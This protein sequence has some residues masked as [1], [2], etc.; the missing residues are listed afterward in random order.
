MKFRFLFILLFF[1][2]SSSIA[3]GG[4][5]HY[6]KVSAT[7]E[8][9]KGKVYASY[10]PALMEVPEY[11]DSYTTPTA[12]TFNSVSE[13]VFYL[14]AKPEAGYNLVTWK[15]GNAQIGQLPYVCDNFPYLRYNVTGISSTDKAS[16][17]ST[18]FSAIFSSTWVTLSNPYPTSAC[19]ATI[20]RPTNSNGTSVTLTATIPSG[21]N[22]TWVGWRDIHT[23][24]IISTSKTYTFTVDKKMDLEPLIKS[25]SFNNIPDGF[26][27]IKSAVTNSDGKALELISNEF[28]LQSVVGSVSTFEEDAG[29]TRAQTQLRKDLILTDVS[30]TVPAGSVMYLKY[31]G[32]NTYELFSQGVNLKKVTSG[33]HH[34]G[35]A[36]DADYDGSYL[37]ITDK[38]DGKYGLS[39]SIAFSVSNYTVAFT[40][41]LKDKGDNKL[42]MEKTDDDYNMWSIEPITTPI[43]TITTVTSGDIKYTTLRSDFSYVIPNGSNT[44]AYRV[45]SISDDFA[46][47]EEYEQGD[48]I[49]A[50]VPTILSYPSSESLNIIPVGNPSFK[51]N[52]NN[53]VLYNNYGT[54]KHDDPHTDAA[55][56]TVRDGGEPRGDGI[57]YFSKEKYS[58]TL[59]RLSVN[60][61]DVVGFW[62]P[63]TNSIISG[64]E[65]YATQ[66]CALFPKEVNLKDLPTTADQITYKLVD[67]LTVAYVDGTNKVIYAK[68]D[69][70]A[71]E[72][73]AGENVD[74]MA[75]HYSSGEYA[76]AHYG[77]HSNWVAIKVASMP[78]VVEKDMIEA[79][80]KVV[81]G[82]SP[83][84]TIQ[85]RVTKLNSTNSNYNPNTYSIANFYGTQAFNGTTYFFAKPVANEIGQIIWAMW[86]GE[87]FV[88]PQQGVNDSG[89]PINDARLTGSVAPE[90]NLYP[91]TAAMPEKAWVYKF[92][93]LI[94]KRA[95]S[96][97]LKAE[98]DEYVLYP[99][100]PLETMGQMGEGEVYT[101]IDNLGS[102]SVASVKYYNMMGVESDVPFQGVN[103]VVTRYD[104]GSQSTH[105]ML[106]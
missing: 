20:N 52:I 103:I 87:K 59:Y 57:G 70:G 77:D 35:N 101:A 61:N 29:I 2:F 69:N 102:K 58:G 51:Y 28:C 85:G 60:E 23:G 19:T 56:V 42:S 88:V 63:V 1:L 99:L 86:D 33:T 34:G 72:Q 94:Q 5:I 43:K 37:T 67:P 79:T 39:I 38:G 49:Y 48:T 30:Q 81:D 9:G 54:H 21:S 71:D 91:S 6:G 7:G 32:N 96:S 74:F 82:T 25:S 13:K 12:P 62:T 65:A 73:L 84:R 98:T 27:S 97:S 66:P 31:M 75:Q 92:L 55:N 78:T 8:T 36:G 100:T 44:K 90:W 41:N 14:Y 47:L 26:Y 89:E 10:D 16:P 4:S 68:D 104:D 22:S 17:T 93:G 83:N 105:K 40:L 95:T 18:S 106:K 80:G 50:G 15:K 76:D 46:S 45:E 53:V 24:E 3:R 11:Y 64:N